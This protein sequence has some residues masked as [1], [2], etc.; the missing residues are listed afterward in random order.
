MRA[1]LALLL[2]LP[3]VALG[4]TWLVSSVGSRHFSGGSHCEF[5]PGLGLEHGA[6][7][8]GFY[9]N[10]DCKTSFY[11]GA[12]YVALEWRR[13]KAGFVGIAVTGYER[14]ITLAPGAMLAY[15]EIGRAH[16]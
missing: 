8:G 7:L 1:L 16:V 6:L 9:R 13:W 15:E 10:S 11:A 3:S 4:D 14:A 12:R 2:L 5:N